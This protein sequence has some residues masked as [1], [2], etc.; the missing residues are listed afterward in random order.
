MSVNRINVESLEELLEAIEK[1]ESQQDNLPIYILFK[2]KII[3]D[4]NKSEGLRKKRCW[5]LSEIKTVL[6]DA[7]DCIDVEAVIDDY[8]G[9]LPKTR[10][11]HYITCDLTP[12][13]YG[14]GTA[15]CADHRF[16]IVKVPTLLRYGGPQR[17]ETREI[18]SFPLLALLFEEDKI[19]ATKESHQGD[20]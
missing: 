16:K 12:A 19:E 15:L 7:T 9:L 11:M 3:S 10:N 14:P 4:K 13:T 5:T 6:L 20:D 18:V 17:L 8:L 2:D 1:L